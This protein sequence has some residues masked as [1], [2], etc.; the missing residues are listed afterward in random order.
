M[1]IDLIKKLF[2]V[3]LFDT[4]LWND[5]YAEQM[6]SLGFCHPLGCFCYF[7]V[8]QGNFIKLLSITRNTNYYNFKI[9]ESYLLM[10]GPSCLGLKYPY[11]PLT[12]L[13]RYQKIKFQEKIIDIRKMNLTLNF[14]IQKQQIVCSRQERHQKCYENGLDCC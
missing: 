8:K 5:V 10:C 9:E 11:Q 4:G 2:L 6:V 3:L 13:E 12:L 14:N 1:N 7:S